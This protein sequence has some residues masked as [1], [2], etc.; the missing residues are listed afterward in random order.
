MHQGPNK[1]KSKKSFKPVRKEA[2]SSAPVHTSASARAAA[3]SRSVAVTDFHQQKT[4]ELEALLASKPLP[5][6]ELKQF[7]DGYLRQFEQNYHGRAN[8][9]QRTP[10]F[11]KASEK[12]IE[13]YYA[14]LFGVNNLED[15]ALIT[16]EFTRNFPEGEKSLIHYQ[17]NLHF[18]AFIEKLHIALKTKTGND[19]KFN[20]TLGSETMPRRCVEVLLLQSLSKLPLAISTP[21]HQGKP[22][23]SDVPAR[24]NPLGLIIAELVKRTTRYFGTGNIKNATTITMTANALSHFDIDAFSIFTRE[25]HA[26]LRLGI[27]KTNPI[28]E[29]FINTCLNS[30]QPSTSTENLIRFMHVICL[31]SPEDNRTQY[32][33]SELAKKFFAKIAS[34]LKLDGSHESLSLA[35]QLFIL[36]N[37][38]GAAFPPELADK[39]A[40]YVER[41][42]ETAHG[43]RFERVIGEEII[44][45]AKE[46]AGIYPGLINPMN[47]NFDNPISAELGMESDVAYT[48]GDLKVCIQIDGDKYHRHLGSHVDTQ[49]TKLRDF[50]FQQQGWELVKFS[51]SEKGENYANAQLLEKVVIPTY[52]L[53]T[54]ENINKM[55]EAISELQ[56]LD[57][58]KS[59]ITERTA[60]AEQLSA[61][62][63][64]AQSLT[65]IGAQLKKAQADLAAYT[66]KS[67]TL[68]AELASLEKTTE[69]KKCKSDA[70]EAEY[71]LLAS[72]LAEIEQERKSAMDSCTVASETLKSYDP[73]TKTDPSITRGSLTVA[74]TEAETKLSLLTIAYNKLEGNIKSVKSAKSGFEQA[75]QAARSSLSAQQLHVA[76]NKINMAQTEDCIAAMQS[77]IQSPVAGTE[78][79][80][81]YA[82]F[83]AV[84]KPKLASSKLRLS[85]EAFIPNP[86]RLAMMQGYED[87]ASAKPYY[88]GSSYY[89]TP[90]SAEAMDGDH[91]ALTGDEHFQNTGYFTDFRSHAAQSRAPYS[92]DRDSTPSCKKASY[93]SRPRG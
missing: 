2:S 69:Q 77:A 75:Y 28:I 6:T 90:G 20:L 11:R 70:A 50:C 32:L 30:I 41:F 53:K 59:L 55:S 64:Q 82:S 4:L 29:Q 66:E 42:A 16:D 49:R 5:P 48:D 10:L 52:E 43:S 37:I 68:N 33:T 36:R 54:Q 38:Y 9:S 67:K 85:A 35:S 84:A 44:I 15:L 58:S 34:T 87:Y 19:G 60:L 22:K 91:Y 83:Q 56:A 12:F 57:A 88:P 26:V 89:S 47:F 86:Q 74:L 61:C 80:E 7:V 21:M 25:A 39:I 27:I 45:A 65:T 92:Q 79:L 31:L 46:L 40:P 14:K 8:I 24:L 18:K 1:T 93:G 17:D 78:L 72:K 73:K 63:L 13:L 81:A 23:E 76:E 71:E 51:D 3:P 62:V